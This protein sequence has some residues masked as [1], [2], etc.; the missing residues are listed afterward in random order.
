MILCR[1]HLSSVARQPAPIRC[2]LNC[3]L[4]RSY[5]GYQLGYHILVTSLVNTLVTSA[6]H[7]F[8]RSDIR[9][10]RAIYWFAVG[11]DTQSPPCYTLFKKIKFLSLSY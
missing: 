7:H 3:V 8:M 6:A 9:A 11:L 5:R 10:N 2:A 1:V 4:G